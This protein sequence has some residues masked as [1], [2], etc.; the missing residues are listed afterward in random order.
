MVTPERARR[1]DN[2]ATGERS[3]SK[4]LEAVLARD[5]RAWRELV[6]R[7]EGKLRDAIRDAGSDERG[8]TDSEIDDVL[9]DFWLLLLENDL[10]RLRDFRGN[11]LSGWLAMMACQVAS[12]ALKKL[13][14]HSPFLMSPA[15][16]SFHSSIIRRRSS[17]IEM[18][19]NAGNE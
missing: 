4:L 5:A 17:S 1:I 18:R 9:G 12:N 8:F 15:I 14:R 11:D 10:C 3:D 2:A 7:H 16:S 13:V 6:R 19:P